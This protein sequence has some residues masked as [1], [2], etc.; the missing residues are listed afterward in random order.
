MLNRL[1]DAE[2]ENAMYWLRKIA[3]DTQPT[4]W[5]EESARNAVRYIDEL[6]LDVAA[7]QTRVERLTQNG[8]VQSGTLRQ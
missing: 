5:A 1:T 7:L 2:I 6:Q 8:N 3:P 4:S